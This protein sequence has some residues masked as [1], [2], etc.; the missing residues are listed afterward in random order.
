MDWWHLLESIFK[1]FFISIP[2]MIIW[3][4]IKIKWKEWGER[5]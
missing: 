1:A 5:R 4:A 3:I 2:I